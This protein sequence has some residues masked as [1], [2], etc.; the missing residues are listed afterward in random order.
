MDIFSPAVLNRVVQDLKASAPTLF[1]LN[2]F[3]P[4]TSVSDQ[5]EI[6][7]DVLTGKPRLAPFVSPMVEGQVVHGHAGHHATRQVGH[8]P[9]AV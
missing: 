2:M 3:F 9:S 1:L 4:E 5:E 6:F 8:H 7:F